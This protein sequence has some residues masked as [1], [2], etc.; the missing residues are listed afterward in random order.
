[1]PRSRA[2]DPPRDR[3]GALKTL[4][5]LIRPR[6]AQAAS[7]SLLL[8]LTAALG[9]V[10]P[11]FVRLVIDD[12]IPRGE[13]RLLLLVGAGMLLFY[14]LTAA[15]G[16]AAM[17]FSYA[18]TQ[19]V[20]SEVR[21][22]AYGKLLRLPLARFTSERSGSL[23]SRVVSDV[24]ALE[25]MIQSG[26]SRL[27]GQLFSVVFVLAVLFA[28]DWVLALVALAIVFAMAFFTGVYQG[29]LRES[30]RRI[31]SRVG[32]LTATATEAIG[33]IGVV[34]SFANEGLE[35]RRF[36]RDNDRYVAGNLER[37]KQVGLMEAL[38]G[39][40]AD[41]GLAAVL[42][43]GGWLVVQRGLT[44]GELSAF[45]L[46]L[47]NLIGPVRSV[48]FFNN[49]LQAGLAALERVDEL[50]HDRP[51]QEGGRTAVPHGGLSFH[52]VTFRYPGGGAPALRGLSFT[53]AP[54][55][56]V[57]LVGP[58]GAG[59]S[60]VAKLVSRLYDP[61]EGE[62]LLGGFDLRTYALSALRGRVAV[63][64]QEPTLFSGSVLDNIRY[65]KPEAA[66]D[67]VREAARLANAEAFI[68]GLPQGFDTEI[69]E[70]GVKL[71]G[72][73]K[74]RVAIARAILK[75]AAVLILDEATSSL[76]TESEAVIQDALAG[77]FERRSRVTT[78][79]IAHRL[80][81]VLGADAILVLNNGQLVERGTHR[82]L[83]ARR[84]LYWAL[85]RL[86]QEDGRRRAE[87]LGD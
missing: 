58:S 48:M 42:V 67:E 79:I 61:D 1:M 57:A 13:G 44:V 6:W 66:D 34:K 80:S 14:L 41:L 69:G 3:K 60:T 11:Q 36:E 7:L 26:A 78:L 27:L 22:E 68:L 63:V 31:R 65:A 16:Y 29:P 21:L 77:L 75:E 20:I 84:G 86:A 52:G 39:L 62:I 17:Y 10:F 82:E 37:R 19:R 18:F 74:Q 64:P 33:N 70:R 2:A 81:T 40:S 71:S 24:N 51:E 76:D 72:G 59:K 47:G 83:V 12:L 53:V 54:G 8:T 45:L 56:T 4:W 87:V 25:T 32:E 9:Q 23:V 5:R 46:Y 50:L 30:A 35:Y 73:Q 15:L 49:A 28:T 55:Q 85:Q 38:V 43:L